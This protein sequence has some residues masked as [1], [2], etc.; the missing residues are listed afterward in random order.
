MK[1]VDSQGKESPETRKDTHYAIFEPEAAAVRFLYEGLAVR[2]DTLREIGD[3]LEAMYPPPKNTKHWETSIMS[4]IVKNPL[5]K[6]EFVCHRHQKIL[7]E[8][9]TKDGLS[10]RQVSKTIMRPPEEWIVV[11]VPAIVTPELWADAN[12]VLAKN[13]ANAARNGKE[14]YLLTGL[15]KCAHCG[16][17]YQGLSGKRDGR[18]FQYYRCAHIGRIKARKM[19]ID[20]KNPSIRCAPI[21]NAV[22][23]QVVKVLT[24]PEVLIKQLES[25]VFGDKN[26][27]LCEQIAHLE[28]ALAEKAA[29]DGKLLKA[30]LAGA[31]DENEY[32]DQRR[33]VKEAVSKL[34]GE[35]EK[36]KAQVITPEEF[37]DK[38]AGILALAKAAKKGGIGLN[39]SFEAQK[40]LIKMMVDRVVWDGEKREFQLEGAIRGVFPLGAIVS[41]LHSK[42]ARKPGR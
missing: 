31:F 40:R 2:G 16:N 1:F 14:E 36:L 4:T 39:L 18:A 37:E 34:T 8:K 35:R 26:R 10:M 38:K 42:P 17:P 11:Q 32:A 22:W 21:D 23:A 7:V 33:I 25:A 12:A 27:E 28:S 24:Q 13:K 30:Y 15:I 19:E 20:C 5:Y 29:A 3:Q 6:G 9:P 41:S